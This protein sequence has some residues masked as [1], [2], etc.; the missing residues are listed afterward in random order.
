MKVILCEDVENLG[1]MG[2]TVNVAPGYARNYLVPRKLAVPMESA[3]AKQIQHE[4]AIIKR[5]EE[6][7]KVELASV[8]KQ[9]EEVTVEI[10]MRAG[11]GG[12]LFGSVTTAQ[13]S[14]ELKA[15]GYEIG[16][17]Q[18]LLDEAIKQLGIHVV[19]VKLGSGV[20]GEI[21]VL[22]SPVDP[23]AA[24][25]ETEDETDEAPEAAAEPDQAEETAAPRI[26]DTV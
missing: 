23:P 9:L 6:K 15:K 4:L 10:L 20:F 11:E 12:K 19:K 5:R 16:R 21:K 17:K 8:A 1:E 25:T 3:S 2:E 18:V 7:R 24:E 22:V 26:E 13:I 14:D